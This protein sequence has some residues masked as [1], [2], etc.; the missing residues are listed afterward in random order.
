[1]RREHLLE[2]ISLVGD[3]PG[4]GWAFVALI[5][6]GSDLLLAACKYGV[7]QAKCSLPRQ[8]WGGD[9]WSELV[10]SCRSQGAGC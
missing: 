10:H 5:V 7:S 1:M 8:E 3:I 4:A 9:T 2:M 6:I